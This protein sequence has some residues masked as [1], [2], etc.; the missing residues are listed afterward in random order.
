M[1]KKL[2]LM[3]PFTKYKETVMTTSYTLLHFFLYFLFTR[4]KLTIF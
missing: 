2:I 1:S 4:L 3:G